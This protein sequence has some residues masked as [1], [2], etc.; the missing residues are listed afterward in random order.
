MAQTCSPLRYPG[1]KTQLAKFIGNLI[2]INHLENAIYIE[3]F[4]GGFGVGIDLLYNNKVDS[5]ILNDLDTPVYSVWYAILNESERLIDDINN[6]T[7]DISEWN[8]QKNIYDKLCKSNEYSYKLA[9]AT[10]FLNRTN[11]SGIM[12]AG[13]I[14]GKEQKGKYKLDCRFNKDNLIKK[15]KKIESNKSKIYLY[16]MDAINF[17]ENV[18]LSYNPNEVFIFFDP[19]YYK[20]GKSL[21]NS[22]FEDDDHKR[23]ENNIRL[24]SDYYWMLTYD[25]HKTIL[26]LYDEYK[27]YLYRL[28][29]SVSKKVKSQELLVVS[30]KMQVESFGKIQIRQ[31]D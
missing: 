30:N 3:P 23:L 31:I 22:F 10:F 20:Q 12:N 1:G 15:I 14:G 7:I 18:I 26:N 16:N 9:F 5:V 19:P 13:P 8:K 11:R 24:L 28:R 2:E 25:N 27:K 29:Y 6:T 17:I 4:A 21:Y